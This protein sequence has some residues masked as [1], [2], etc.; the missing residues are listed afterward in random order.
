MNR[1]FQ[2]LIIANNHYYSLHNSM[3]ITTQI[4][5]CYGKV[6][7]WV[8]W[9]VNC[10]RPKSSLNSSTLISKTMLCSMWFRA[11]SKA[12]YLKFCRSAGKVQ[13]CS[14]V[15]CMLLRTPNRNWHCHLRLKRGNKICPRNCPGVDQHNYRSNWKNNLHLRKL[16]KFKARKASK[17]NR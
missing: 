17:E 11:R 15:I 5:V 13:L 7:F 8:K 9:N 14:A 1:E 3:S 6:I 16:S 4:L 2:V 10:T 12:L